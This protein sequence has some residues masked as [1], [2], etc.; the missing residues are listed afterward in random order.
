[1]SKFNKILLVVTCLCVMSS[2][3]WARTNTKATTNFFETH[4]NTIDV[5]KMG[6]SILLANRQ[7]GLEIKQ[8]PRGFQLVRL[9]G[10]VDNQDFLTKLTNFRNLFEI[11]MTLDP[12]FVRRDDRGKTKLGHFV[13]LKEMAGDAFTIGANEAKTVSWRKEGKTDETT[14]HLTWKEMDVKENKS[15]LD[16]EVTITLRAGDPLS[17][18]RINVRNRS[19]RYGIERV[20][21]PL[22]TLAPIGAGKD[23][24]FLYPRYRGGLFYN[25]FRD[26]YNTNVWY[27]H[28]FNMQ[29][30][31]LYN[32]KSKKGLYL[33]TRDP[34]ASFMAYTIKHR[35]S[36]IAWEPG[37]FPPNITFASEDFNLP[38]DCVVGP[39]KGD[40]YDAAQIYRK[41]A[42]KQFWCRKGKLSVRKDIPKWYKEAPLYLYAQLGD[43]ATGTHSL[44]K[45]LPIAEKHLLEFLEWAGDVKLPC[46]FYQVTERI[47]GLTSYDLP[48][49]VYRAP[50]LG[51]WAGFSTHETHCG[52]YPDIPML[53][54]LPATVARLKKAGG[55]VCPYVPLEFFDP[56][57][58]QNAPYAKEANPHA[59]R[60]LYGAF[61]G[62]G[63]N[64]NWQMCPW[65]DWWRNRL[66]ETCELMLEKE[67]FS[68]FYLDV[69][70]GGSI[71]CYWTPHGH[72][73]AGGDSMTKGMHELV[74]II[75]NAVKTKDPQA[76]TTG[77]NS[78][79]NMIDVTDGI[80]QVSLWPE[81]TAPIF[82][83]VYQDY[84]LRYGLELPAGP[85]WEGRYKDTWKKDH[86]FIMGAS[87]F[88]EGM[89]VGRLRLRPRDMAI[90]FQNP[91][92]K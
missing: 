64:P 10:I 8:S 6:D 58:A 36:M 37:H 84:I 78:S 69:L 77:E 47:P 40:W 67:H 20:R 79:E 70:Q 60:D 22:L 17:Y 49:C 76:I 52:N 39:F 83:T 75:T 7:I 45:N 62:W 21:F 86:F 91:E 3:A 34:A 51:R 71:P 25:A 31:A 89:Q 24:V 41:W 19:G 50:R 29:F 18:W 14:L 2:L 56:G 26:G 38:Y 15:A 48:I 81:N 12:K 90:S 42:V 73:A 80:L 46:N 11:R 23:N 85:G 72:S 87:M 4:K 74:E 9:Y 43:S 28:N 65:S 61:R 5:E 92:H 33:G 66:K 63:T 16:V 55:M 32:D 27:P 44:E 59:L 68:G 82:A 1:M 53:P 13:I 54:E 88:V 30:Q 35:A 57:P